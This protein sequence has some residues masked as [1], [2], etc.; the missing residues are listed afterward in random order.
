ML[1]HFMTQDLVER[2]RTN[3]RRLHETLRDVRGLQ[4]MVAES[5]Q[6]ASLVPYMVPVLLSRPSA[7][8]PRLRATGIPVW[9][10][11]YSQRGHCKVTDWYAEALIQIPC[12]QSLGAEELIRIIDA[13]KSVGDAA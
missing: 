13:L 1:R 4:P 6:S 11:E 8:L 7:Q 2:R 10:W 12:H 3:F 5:G 9:R